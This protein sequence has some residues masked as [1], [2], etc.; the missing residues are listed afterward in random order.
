MTTNLMITSH[1]LLH[2]CVMRCLARL[3]NSSL[4]FLLQVAREQLPVCR[5][6]GR[7]RQIS[8]GLKT[9]RVTEKQ[10]GMEKSGAVWNRTSADRCWRRGECESGVC[11][12]PQTF[13]RPRPQFHRRYS[14]VT[15]RALNGPS[16]RTKSLFR[17]VPMKIEVALIHD[18]DLNQQRSSGVI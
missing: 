6:S 16:K 3:Y 11:K 10:H 17:R 1:F 5:G 2:S 4:L 15:T 18:A 13:W 9:V 7:K 14:C 12:A 8:G